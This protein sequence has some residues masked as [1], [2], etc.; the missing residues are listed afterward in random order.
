MTAY[1]KFKDLS[2]RKIA[3]KNYINSFVYKSVIYNSGINKHLKF[4]IMLIMQNF[5]NLYK[6]NKINSRCIYTNFSRGIQR[7]NFSSKSEFKKKFSEGKI[8]GFKKAS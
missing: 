2:N 3:E 6:I 5:K 1:I 4:K 7:L 8:T